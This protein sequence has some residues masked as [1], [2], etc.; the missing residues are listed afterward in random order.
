MYHPNL[1]A[2]LSL[3]AKFIMRLRLLSIEI[4]HEIMN[5]PQRNQ[6]KM[7]EYIQETIEYIEYGDLTVRL[8]KRI[9]YLRRMVSNTEMQCRIR[10]RLESQLIDMREKI[11]YMLNDVGNNTVKG[12]FMSRLRDLRLQLMK[13]LTQCSSRRKINLIK[14][15][16]QMAVDLD[17]G[18]SWQIMN[19]KLDY[20]RRMLVET[21]MLESNRK[22][23][24]GCITDLKLIVMGNIS[25]DMNHE[26]EA[27]KK[28]IEEKLDDRLGPMPAKK[29]RKKDT[30]ESSKTET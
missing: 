18:M 4:G 16:V 27:N 1:V 25:R 17:H 28:R 29:K 12:C 7:V 26:F 13:D 3:K 8:S 20:L 23:V 30:G 10:H 11:D 9:D 19:N 21:I 15:V 2:Y 22:R 5:C 6:H 14:F 24:D